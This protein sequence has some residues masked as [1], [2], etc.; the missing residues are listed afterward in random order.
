MSRENCKLAWSSAKIVASG[1]SPGVEFVVARMTFGRR[2]ELM[3]KVRDL[4]A[5]LEFFEAGREARNEMEASLL[6]GE[7]DR[8]YLLWGLEEVRGLDIDGAPA[9]AESLIDRGPEELFQEALAA[10]KAE[11]GLTETERKN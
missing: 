10:V 9:T 8:L 6:G 4:A 3:R 2:L 1:V 7:I 5:R 11:C